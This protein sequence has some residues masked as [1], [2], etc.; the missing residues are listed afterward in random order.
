MYTADDTKSANMAA[1]TFIEPTMKVDVSGLLH[2]KDVMASTICRCSCG[3]R[4]TFILRLFAI[5]IYSKEKALFSFGGGYVLRALV[6]PLSI[7]QKMISANRFRFPTLHTSVCST[8]TH[9]QWFANSH[10]Q[11]DKYI[12]LR[13]ALFFLSHLCLAVDRVPAVRY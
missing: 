8:Y 9:S 3:C 13:F 2:G 7:K 4:T 1:A 12:S 11:L 6:S 5:R 10:W